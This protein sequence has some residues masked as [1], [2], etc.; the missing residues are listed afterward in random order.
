MGFEM[1]TFRQVNINGL[2]DDAQSGQIRLQTLSRMQPAA[3]DGARATRSRLARGSDETASRRYLATYLEDAGSEGLLAVTAPSRPEIV[4]DMQIQNTSTTPQLDASSVT[5]QQTAYT[6]PIFGG[7]MVVDVDSAEKTLVAINGKVSPP[8][9]IDPIAKLSAQEAWN[10]LLAWADMPVAGAPPFPP[11]L[12]WYLG[13]EDGLWHLI[14]HF[15]AL[16]LSPRPEALP[17]DLPPLRHACVG[18]S[19]RSSNPRYD[20]FV[21]AHDGSVPFY[22]SSTP[23]LDIPAPMDG[24]DSNNNLQ[25][26]FGLQGGSSTYLLKDPLRNIETYDYA[27]ADLDQNIP[28]PA[29]PISHVSANFGNVSPQAVSAHYHAKLVFDFYN[30]ELKRDGIDDKGMKL[31]SVIN[32]YASSGQQAPPEWSNAVWWQGKMWYG[33]A[34]GRS[35]A[36]FL[37]VIAHELT[38]GV[39]SSSSN[40]IYRRLPGALNESYSDIFGIIIS[41]WYPGAPNPVAN[42]KWEIGSGLGNAGGPLRDF[43][44]PAKSG[45]PYHMNQY[46]VLPITYDNGGVHIYSGIHNKAIYALLTEVDVNGQLTFPTKELVLLLYLTLTRLTPTS[47][48]SDSR[49]TLENVT[50]TYHSANQAVRTAR[51]AAI[52]RAFKSV[53]I[54]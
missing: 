17:A 41:N 11:I 26:F 18:H 54:V 47:D 6:I 21:D 28:L 42:W 49:K 36:R 22:F 52:D 20:Y 3:N 14:Y 7:R 35:F 46:R 5:Y 33:Q 4:P 39:T 25:A 34:N 48:F 23:T 12:T 9:D 32:V 24:F 44:D 38:H 8:P 40:L 45:Q 1:A 43:S 19:P 10:K 30:D 15:A 29:Q 51:L 16:P 13:E 2:P 27:F 53:G 37:D 50:S 31:I